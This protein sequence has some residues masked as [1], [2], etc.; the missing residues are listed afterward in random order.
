VEILAFNMP[1]A[2]APAFDQTQD[3]TKAN[4]LLIFLFT[5]T[6]FWAAGLLFVLEPMFAKMILPVFGGSPAVW[7]TSMVF[8]QSALFLAYIYSHLVAQRP[9]A[10]SVLI[11]S[12]AI[13]TPL[14]VLPIGIHAAPNL[15]TVVNHPTVAVLLIAV[16]SIGLP[17]FFVATSA[18]L[19]QRWFAHTT[20][21]DASDPYFLYAASNA[22]SLI[23][24]ALYPCLLE[25]MLRISQQAS[26]W[27]AGYG[28]FVV[29]TV[30]CGIAGYRRRA[31]DQLPANIES[32]AAPRLTEKLLWGALALVPASLLY[33]YTAQL[34]TD[35]PPVPLLWIIPLCLYLLTFIAAFAAPQAWLRRSERLLV[36]VVVAAMLMSLFGFGVHAG[37]W[38]ANGL[39]KLFCFVVIALAFH[40][41]LAHRRPSNR[42]LTEYYLWVS[43]GGIL[44][45]VLNSIIAPAVFSDFWEYPLTLVLAAALLPKFSAISPRRPGNL[46]A[47]VVAIAAV[48]VLGIAMQFAR[49]PIPPVASAMTA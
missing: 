14:L 31:Q 4:R 23:G 18:P 17:F 44:G 24:L 1:T 7:N 20:H 46:K 15:S 33:T 32:E 22:G 12:I 6:V 13:L 11:H 2:A 47:L 42:Y 38:G 30:A 19:L 35:F 27:S 48:G 8:F 40:A 28:L 37:D 49:S 5:T 26:L 16:S 45:G 9:P 36:P 25:P 41:E 39:M 3:A 21:R 29:L 10:Q 43:A 34:S